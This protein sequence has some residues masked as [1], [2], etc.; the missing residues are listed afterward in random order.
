MA[1][2]TGGRGGEIPEQAVRDAGRYRGPT[3]DGHLALAGRAR[4]RYRA[5]DPSASQSEGVVASRAT[6]SHAAGIRPVDDVDPRPCGALAAGLVQLLHDDVAQELFIARMTLYEL[7][8]RSSSS[9][10]DRSL[11]DAALRHVS[12]ALDDV[13]G[14]IDHLRAQTD[15]PEPDLVVALRRELVEFTARS[16]ID[17]VYSESGATSDA[18]P[19]LI[20]GVLLIVREALA[21]VRKHANASTVRLAVRRRPG[22]VRVTLADDGRGFRPEPAV[23]TVRGL[24]LG[25]PAM[26]ERARVL[27]GRLELRSQPGEGT[28]L[29]IDVPLPGRLADAG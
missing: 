27:G 19:R 6:R 5:R 25:L 7:A 23:G 17:V 3:T 29:T 4:C 24:G 10:G 21:N 14:A 8:Q 16:G 12:A 15:P 13:R 1:L 26:R 11:V 20:A 22:W 2:V 18:P 9:T 28:R